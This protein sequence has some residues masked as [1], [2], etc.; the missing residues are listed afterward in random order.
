M[1]VKITSFVSFPFI[2]SQPQEYTST[3]KP[4]FYKM[5]A[6]PEVLC[7]YT[8]KDRP[9]AKTELR[10]LNKVMQMFSTKITVVK[11]PSKAELMQAISECSIEGKS[12][13]CFIIGHGY[14]NAFLC[15]D[16]LLP[17]QD[18]VRQMNTRI[19]MDT[20]KLLITQLC[21]KEIP[22]G[23]HVIQGRGRDFADSIEPRGPDMLIMA[24]TL[25]DGLAARNVMIP[26]FAKA[27]K[28]ARDTQDFHELFLR[29]RW[30]I[31]RVEPTQV[32]VLM[33]T[34]KYKFSLTKASR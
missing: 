10:E 4:G 21:R 30:E 7:I 16:G 12:L 24:A 28:E 17:L 14:S 33:S 8:D 27:L 22:E 5:N 34:L 15:T 19:L 18:V 11:N 9:H 20:P 2:V 25:M 32:P 6:Q 31:E 13:I 26:I 1:Y 23:H 3:A 29:V